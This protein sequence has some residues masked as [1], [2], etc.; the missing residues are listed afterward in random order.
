MDEEVGGTQYSPG[1]VA[2]AG[3]PPG[4]TSVWLSPDFFDGIDW[5]E[6]PRTLAP[7]RG[8]FNAG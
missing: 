5:P 1:S 7:L 8:P 4:I 3:S 6:A 2:T